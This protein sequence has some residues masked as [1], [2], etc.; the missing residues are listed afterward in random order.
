MQGRGA[1][2]LRQMGVSDE[3]IA[4]AVATQEGQRQAGHP[5]LPLEEILG[6]VQAKSA[7]RAGAKRARKVGLAARSLDLLWGE[8]QTE[9][10]PLRPVQLEFDFQKRGNMSIGFEYFDAI[11]QRLRDAPVTPAQRMGAVAALHFI[12]R[13]LEWEYHSCT[14]LPS[15]LADDMGVDRA[16]MSRILKLLEKVG[17]IYRV[18]S[19]AE[20]VIVVS[21]E[22]MWRGKFENHAAA[23]RR[24][25]MEVIDG[26]KAA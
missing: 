24:F 5:V 10:K 21:P 8:P 19:G 14:K 25:K 9:P 16:Q 11:T 12:A 17:A 13:N 7:Q 2:A 6:L 18:K 23:V 26:G 4:L 1:V 20:R 22:G 3:D 15:E